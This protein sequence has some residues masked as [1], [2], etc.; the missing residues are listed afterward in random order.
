MQQSTLTF[1]N[2]C[3]NFL[4]YTESFIVD[5]LLKLKNNNTNPKFKVCS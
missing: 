2:T 1:K 5:F 3:L 4:D